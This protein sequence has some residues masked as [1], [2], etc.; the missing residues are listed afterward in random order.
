MCI[1]SIEKVA[2]KLNYVLREIQTNG[3]LLHCGYIEKNVVQF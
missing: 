2:F 1:Q 3:H